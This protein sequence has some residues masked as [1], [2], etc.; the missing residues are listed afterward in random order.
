MTTREPRPQRDQPVLTAIAVAA[1]LLV[2]PLIAI[3][4]DFGIFDLPGIALAAGLVAGGRDTTRPLAGL[5]VIALLWVGSGPSEITA[6]TLVLATLMLTIHC[7][8]ALRDSVPGGARI[9]RELAVRWL[10]RGG[11]VVAVT[12]LVY[13]AGIAVHHLGRGD[14]EVVVALA[15]CLLVG[16]ILLLR[17]ET[18]QDQQP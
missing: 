14:S 16:L 2:L 1:A 18:V 8:V 9:G 13:L 10:Q 3:A 7:A 5:L 11:L 12:A 15:L 4:G 6:W 17:N